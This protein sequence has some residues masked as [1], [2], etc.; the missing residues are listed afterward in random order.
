MTIDN[1]VKSPLEALE[2]KLVRI[3]RDA[4]NDFKKSLFESYSKSQ[5]NGILDSANKQPK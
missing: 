2:A 5:Q 4:L 3:L 1:F